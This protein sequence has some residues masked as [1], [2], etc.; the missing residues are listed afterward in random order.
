MTISFNGAP[1]SAF[2]SH[3]SGHRA[4]TVFPIIGVPVKA[5][6]ALL[7]LACTCANAADSQKP[8]SLERFAWLSGS[9]VL[10]D[11][12][13]RVEE[14]WS[15]PATDM[16]IGMSRTLRAGKTAS[17]EFLRIVARDDGVFYV[18]QPRGKPPVEFRLQSLDEMQAVFVN[19]GHADHLR[20]IVYRRNVD[21]TLTATIE[22]VD[23][24]KSFAEDYV[25]RRAAAHKN[26]P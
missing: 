1:D 19:P 26:E 25:Y 4:R 13:R 11:G 14:I 10:D 7:V 17:F 21:G 16:L 5:T 6:A 8:A 15:A 24:G 20:R 23:G 9:W 18:A 22:G 12:S 2:A 3:A